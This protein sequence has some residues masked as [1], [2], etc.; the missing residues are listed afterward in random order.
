[1]SIG[2]WSA[3][4]KNCRLLLETGGKPGNIVNANCTADVV[5]HLEEEG[6][7]AI[8]AKPDVMGGPESG[9]VILI[10]HITP[11]AS[12]WRSSLHSSSDCQSCVVCFN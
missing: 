10:A 6:G 12:T 11:A 4:Y 8:A 5:A 7:C 2:R 3:L 9:S 1:M